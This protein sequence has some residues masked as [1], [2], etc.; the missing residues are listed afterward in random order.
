MFP[1]ANE[2]VSPRFVVTAADISPHHQRSF[3]PEVLS[4]SSTW[5]TVAAG[6]FVWLMTPPELVIEAVPAASLPPPE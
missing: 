1:A 5:F 2:R 6:M 3:V 4:H